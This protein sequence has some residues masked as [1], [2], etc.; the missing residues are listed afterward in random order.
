[1]RTVQVLK[2]ILA[3]KSAPLWVPVR[4]LGG[5]IYAKA[6]LRSDHRAETT[7]TVYPM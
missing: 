3:K 7:D 5:D 2:L 6:H 1:V 4:C